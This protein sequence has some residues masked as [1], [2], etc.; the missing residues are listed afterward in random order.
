[1]IGSKTPDHTDNQVSLPTRSGDAGKPE[2]TYQ[3]KLAGADIK[4]FRAGRYV[5]ICALFKRR[6]GA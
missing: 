2:K 4:R 1:M 6:Q 3:I 5:K